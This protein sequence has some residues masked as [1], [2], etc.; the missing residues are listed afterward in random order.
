[1]TTNGGTGESLVT[2]K[3]SV[4]LLLTERIAAVSC[5]SKITAKVF[6]GHNRWLRMYWIRH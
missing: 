1:M 5:N 4:L 2:V 6:L 3:V